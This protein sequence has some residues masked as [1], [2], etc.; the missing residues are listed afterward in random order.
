MSLLHVSHNTA[1]IYLVLFFFSFFFAA[2]PPPFQSFPSWSAAVSAA[3]CLPIK[4]K[5]KKTPVSS[6][7]D[8]WLVHTP[9]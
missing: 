5:T 2:Q 4:E 8:L 9:A 7:A 1:V 6:R 3:L